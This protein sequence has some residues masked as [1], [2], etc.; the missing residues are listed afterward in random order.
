MRVLAFDPGVVN[1]AYCVADV[2]PTGST[3]PVV[4]AC[5][6]QSI[7]KAKDPIAVIV[8]SM[9]AFLS[10]QREVLQDGVTSVQ[11]EQQVAL[12]ASKNQ[13]IAVALFT[14]YT[15]LMSTG[16]GTLREVTFVHPRAKFKALLRLELP[17]LDGYC[18][19]LKE[20]RGAALKR[21]AV[22][23]AVLLMEHWQCEVAV[24]ALRVAKKNDDIADCCLCA[25]LC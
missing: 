18:A 8:R 9:V 24:Q 21:L 3:T 2:D 23:T 13:S 22:E 6:V 5:A 17:L 10:E 4:V 15:Q 20:A 7:G 1:F 19:R 25:T 11:I 16:H 14:F 12:K